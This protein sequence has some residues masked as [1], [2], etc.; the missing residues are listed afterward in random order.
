M[1]QAWYSSS[2]KNDWVRTKNE[3]DDE[4]KEK[5]NW[6]AEEAFV[7]REAAKVAG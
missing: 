6:G 1:H 4:T 5:G 2:G 7:F 3:D